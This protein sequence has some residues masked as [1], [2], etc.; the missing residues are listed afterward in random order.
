MTETRFDSLPLHPDTL[1][2][3]REVLGYATMTKVQSQSLGPCLGPNDVM[4]KAKTGTGKTL[5]FLIPAIEK[6]VTQGRTDGQIS[7]LTISPTRELAEQILNEG[8]AL[9]RFHQ[10]R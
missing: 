8:L 10:L 6:L 3:L 5:A 2:A 9:S 7:V 4:A 1:R